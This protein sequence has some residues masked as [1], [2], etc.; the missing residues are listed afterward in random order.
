M[1]ISVYD[2][3][4][5]LVQTVT[6]GKFNAGDNQVDINTTTLNSGIYTVRI[7]AENGTLS[8]RISVFK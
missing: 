7:D 3:L 5:Q 1:T 4:G 6:S 8:Q 2:Q